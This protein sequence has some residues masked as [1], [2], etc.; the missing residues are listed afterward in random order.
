MERLVG[1]L[2]FNWNKT[3]RSL[4]N[5]ITCFSFVLG[6]EGTSRHGYTIDD[7]AGHFWPRDHVLG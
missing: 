7:W 3:V 4:G 2:L 1:I 5:T 6:R